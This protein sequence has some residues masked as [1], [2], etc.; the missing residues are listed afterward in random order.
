MLIGFAPPKFVAFRFMVPNFSVKSFALPFRFLG[1][2]FV[3]AAR[4]TRCHE[5]PDDYTRN[6]IRHSYGATGI[7]AVVTFHLCC[8]VFG[9]DLLFLAESMGS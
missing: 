5:L 8:L 2:A 6:T 9:S 3:G 7:G 4:K 1:F